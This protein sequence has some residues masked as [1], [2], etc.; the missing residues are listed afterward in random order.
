MCD[1]ASACS[2]NL[3]K[4]SLCKKKA[5]AG[6]VALADI[7]LVNAASACSLNLAKS[8]I[9]TREAREGYVM[10]ANIHHVTDAEPP[11]Q[12]F[13]DKGEMRYHI[14]RKNVAC[15]HVATEIA[16]N[17][18][19]TDYGFIYAQSGNAKGAKMRRSSEPLLT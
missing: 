17:V 6:H 10:L 2:L 13:G 16:N 11:W 8:S 9:C 19:L 12:K 1:A 15:H 5:R 14:V 18:D 4:S 3:A 7:H